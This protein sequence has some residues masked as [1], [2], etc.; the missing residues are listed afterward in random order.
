MS[1]KNDVK[2][3]KWAEL[4]F[5]IIGSLLSNPPQN[6]ILGKS[7]EKLS[8]HEYLHPTKENA[9]I[10]F[11]AST[12][13]RWYY[14]AK[15]SNDPVSALDRKVRSDL[16]ITTLFDSILLTELNEQYNNY[17]HWSYKLHADNLSAL[18]GQK[19][20]ATKKAPSYSTVRRQMKKRGWTKKKNNNLKTDGQ[21]KAA[22]RLENR[23][24]R[25]F[26]SEHVNSLWHLDF[27]EG[28]IASE[29]CNAIKYLS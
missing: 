10:K 17:P 28:L 13:E 18:I 6:G 27:H 16:E 12:I 9:T 7:I 19:Y 8:S 21:I 24:K 3:R 23:E 14:K 15:N 26:E 11:G 2:I 1:K 5:S 25:S 29:Y 20:S 22:N 4:R